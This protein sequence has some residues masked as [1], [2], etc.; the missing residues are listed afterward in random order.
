[1]T[2][3]VSLDGD[4]IEAKKWTASLDNAASSVD[5]QTQKVCRRDGLEDRI[6]KTMR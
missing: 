4:D 6:Q 1:M 5:D 3:I 2:A